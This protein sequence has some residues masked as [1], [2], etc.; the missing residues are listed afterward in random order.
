MKK[1]VEGPGCAKDS[2]CKELACEGGSS[3]HEKCVSGKCALTTKCPQTNTSKVCITLYRPVC[4]SDGKNYSNECFANI[5]GVH[6]IC[7][8]TCPCQQN[9]T[10]P[11]PQYSLP[12]PGWC[13]NGT[14]IS[15]R[16][17]DGCATPPFCSLD[18]YYIFTA[19][20]AKNVTISNNTYSM[21]LDGVTGSTNA[22]ITVGGKTIPAMRRH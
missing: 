7:N 12:Y 5:S 10:F 22:T 11:C 15:G 21:M 16:D 4:G 9:R 13:A 17:D 3:V 8:G 2:D 6:V 20:K 14:M 18:G 19:Q 1:S